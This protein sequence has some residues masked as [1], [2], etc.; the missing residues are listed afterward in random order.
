MKLI[1][2]FFLPP[3]LQELYQHMHSRLRKGGAPYYRGQYTVRD[4]AFHNV[5]GGWE[6]GQGTGGAGFYMLLGGRAGDW[7]S[8]V[9][10]D[11]G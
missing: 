2:L 1:F 4:N 8:R 6:V 11:A 5:E 3:L 7:G 9:I 10:H